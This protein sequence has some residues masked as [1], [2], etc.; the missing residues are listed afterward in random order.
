MKASD[1]FNFEVSQEGILVLRNSC[2]FDT[3]SDLMEFY[4]MKETIAGEP[5]IVGSFNE[6]IQDTFVFDSN[7]D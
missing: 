2:N 7:F 4:L 3:L 6:L 5:E 1:L